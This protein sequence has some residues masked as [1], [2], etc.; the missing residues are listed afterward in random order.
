M[1]NFLTKSTK[2]SGEE[3][4]GAAE[5]TKKAVEGMLKT[6][7]LFT[8]TLDL[9]V[10]WKIFEKKVKDMEIYS[11]NYSE[12]TTDL[13]DAVETDVALGIS[14][15]LVSAKYVY[16]WSGLVAPTLNSFIKLYKTD[17]A[18]VAE[19]QKSILVR[20]LEAEIDIMKKAQSKL[21][22]CSWNFQHATKKLE[23]L[24]EHLAIEFST[25]GKYYKHLMENYQTDDKERA[26]EVLAELDYSK[27]SFDTLIEKLTKASA[28]LDETK[29]KLREENRNIEDLKNQLED[30]KADANVDQ[31]LK[32]SIIDTIE[33]L[34]SKCNEFHRNYT[35]QES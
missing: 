10:P 6:M 22:S 24:S 29:E 31:S 5:I 11:E 17:T 20:A 26:A 13:F 27:K 28:D 33:I 32:Q 30:A 14:A 34:M 16:D 1:C 8:E 9:Y 25:E 3:N 35:P 21:S 2:Y 4:H 7:E 15:Y 23:T 19:G 18:G 12:E